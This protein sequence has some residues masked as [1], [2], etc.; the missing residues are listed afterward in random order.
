MD[1]IETRELTRDDLR[2]AFGMVLQDTWLFKGT[3]RENVTYGAEG[4]V[5]EEAFHAAVEAAHVDHFVRT[6]PGRLRDRPRRG[7]HER[8]GR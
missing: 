6:L 1:G 3:I 2:R 5:S 4:E 7:R 8:L